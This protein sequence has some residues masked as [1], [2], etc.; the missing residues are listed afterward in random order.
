MHVS[1]RADYGVRA[2]LEL[3]ALHA[4]DPDALMRGEEIAGA[5]CIPAKFLEG[6]MRQLRLAG[7]IVARRGAE[8]GYRLARKPDDIAVADVIRALDG[9]LA[10][11][12]GT[13]PEGAEYEGA[14]EHLREVWVA[15]RA[16]LRQVLERV[17][18]QDVLE[19][20][21]PRDVRRLLEQ[22]DAWERR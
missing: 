12:H 14:S 7:L 22:P 21:F 8:G 9:P 13:P 6:I 18:L 1:S 19:G 17:S 4:V 11:V 5:Q 2:L 20:R 3:A 16:A 10:D 15:V